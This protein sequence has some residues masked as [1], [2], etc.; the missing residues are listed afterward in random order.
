MVILYVIEASLSGSFGWE[1]KDLNMI[2][3]DHRDT[4]SKFMRMLVVVV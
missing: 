1:N 4:R 3:L 2:R